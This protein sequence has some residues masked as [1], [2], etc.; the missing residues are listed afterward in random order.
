MKLVRPSDRVD[1]PGASAPVSTGQGMP[2]QFAWTTLTSPVTLSANTNYYLVSYE[3]LGGD[4][5]YEVGLAITT[6]ALAI[7]TAVY[8]GDGQN[9]LPYSGSNMSFVPPNFK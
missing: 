5:W 6:P 3:Q 8:S 9:W 4:Q 2:G 7:N 1:V